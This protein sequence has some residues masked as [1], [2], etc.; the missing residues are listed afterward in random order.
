MISRASRQGRE[1]SSQS[2]DFLTYLPG[3]LRPV[4][5]LFYTLETVFNMFCMG[6][7]V[8]G[9]QAINLNDLGPNGQFIHYLYLVVFYAFMVLTPFQ[10]VSICTGHT[11]NVLMEIYKA[12]AGAVVFLL[13]SLTT[14]WNAERQFYLF[15][16]TIVAHDHEDH[17]YTEFRE[18]LPNHPF[19]KFMRG[20]SI[21]SL[22][23]GLIYMLHAAIMI[24]VRLTSRFND[25]G[26]HAPIPLFVLG[27]AF[28]KR[29][30]TY[31]WFRDFCDNTIMDI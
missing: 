23:C 21:S 22:A 13:I 25:H 30:Y 3:A 16:A 18:D 24:D 27:R 19:F 6:Y 2:T 17:G 15:F 7:H 8:T 10:S 12:S 4:L 31:Q 20:Q 14:M 11:P 29:L 5:F 9:F 26:K 28:H 1:L